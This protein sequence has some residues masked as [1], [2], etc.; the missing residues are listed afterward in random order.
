[1]KLGSNAL[2]HKLLTDYVQVF[3]LYDLFLSPL[4]GVDTGF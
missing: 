3:Q 1:M 2:C 4:A